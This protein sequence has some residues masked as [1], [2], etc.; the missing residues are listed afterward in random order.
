MKNGKSW[1]CG[2][3]AALLS[4]AASAQTIQNQPNGGI[5][6][7]F[8]YPDSQTY[9][10]VF[11]APDDLVLESFTLYLN[12]AVGSIRGG[13][14]TWNGNGVYARGYGSPVNLFLSDIVSANSAGGYSFNPNIALKKGDFYVAYLS[15][16]GLDNNQIITTTMPKGTPADNLH[17]FVWN[18]STSPFENSAW[19]YSFNVGNVQFKAAFSPSN[20]TYFDGNGARDDGQVTGGAGTWNSSDPSWTTKTGS[21]NGVYVDD[22]LNNIYFAGALGG[23]VDVPGQRQFGTINFDTTGYELGGSGSLEI[24]QSSIFVGRDGSAKISVE[25]K[26][27][28]LTKIGPG[29]LFLNHANS[30]LGGTDLRDGTITVGDDLALGTGDLRMLIGTASVGTTLRSGAANLKLANRIVVR[31]LGIVD[32]RDETFTL[33]G[34][35][36]DEEVNAGSIAKIGR[37]NLVLTAENSY[38]GGTQLRE[39][40]I[41]VGHNKA[42]GTGNLAISD[43]TTLRAG[44]ADLALANNIDIAGLGKVDTG[45]NTLTLNGSVADG[46]QAI[47]TLSK[48]GSGNLVLNGSNSYTGGTN[49]DEGAITV[50]HNNALGTGKLTMAEGTTLRAG[51][52]N[53][54]VANEIKIT[55]QGTFDTGDNTLTISGSI[56]DGIGLA[57]GFVGQWQ[58]DQGPHYGL[59]DRVYTGQ[60]AAAYLFGGSPSDYQISTAGPLVTNINRKSWVSVY[61]SGTVLGCYVGACGRQAP[62]NL[63]KSTN[64]L[65]RSQGDESAYIIDYAVGPQFTNYAFTLVNAVVPSE[66]IKT[67]RGTLVLT[68]ANNYTGGTLL[69]EG[70]LEVANNRALGTGNLA[71][72]DGTTLRAGAADLA[73]ANNINIAGIGKVDTGANT[74]TLNGEITD[75]GEGSGALT[76][77]GTGTLVLNGANSYTGGT[78][79]VAGRLKG[80]STSLQGAIA[81]NSQVEFN[82]SSTGTYAGVMSGTGQF[83]KTG[84]GTL[85]LTGANTYTG[86]TVV[87]A[88]RL[89]GN[90]ASLQGTIVNNSQVEFNQGSTGTYAG[91]MSG[92]GQLIKTG[93]GTL[94]LTGANTYTGGTLV[95]AGRLTGNSASLQGTIVNNSE[96]EFNQSSSGNYAGTMVGSGQLFKTGSGNLTLTGVNNITGQAYVVSGTLTVNNQLAAGGLFVRNTATLAGTGLIG[97]NVTVESGGV[98]APGN[99]PGT[100]SVAGNVTFASGSIFTPEIDGRTYSAAGGAGSYDL[101]SASG[102]ISLSG[103]LTPKLRAISGAASNTFTPRIGDSFIVMSS[104]NVTGSFSGVTQPSDGLPTNTRFDVLYR[105]TNVTLTITPGSYGALALANNWTVNATNAG[106]A[107]DSIRPAAGVRAGNL[108]S[109]FDGIYGLDT[110]QLR[111]T[112]SQISGEVHAQALQS[113]IETERSTFGAMLQSSCDMSCTDGGTNTDKSLWIRYVGNYA[114]FE[115]DRLASGYSNNNNGVVGGYTIVST[116]KVKFGVAASYVENKVNS[117]YGGRSQSQAGAGYLYFHYLPSDRLLLSGA[118]GMSFAD[119]ATTRTVTTTNNSVTATS[120]HQSTSIMINAKAS[121]RT[122]KAGALSLWTNFGLNLVNTSVGRFGENASNPDFALALGKVQQLSGESLVGARLQLDQGPLKVALMTDWIYQVGESPSVIRPVE[123]GNARW[124]VSGA[125]FARS[126]IQLGAQIGAQLSEHL[127]F[128]GMYQYSN[129]GRGHSVNRAVA[130]VRMAF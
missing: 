11:S 57:L 120:K 35:I 128:F 110:D 2:L 77:I 75:G 8:G 5:I 33:A 23:F 119:S 83:I 105:P 31:S 32:T 123:M 52:N 102:T 19:N 122:W 55:R 18:N 114:D 28:G 48:I 81:N 63:V 1:R 100:L 34:Q 94:T 43:G 64:G 115:T 82:Q 71:M 3:V 38:T 53:F 29:E 17:Y 91:V 61:D 106:F 56:G 49:L 96:V 50:G 46:P 80:N 4:T 22:F 73:L 117:I 6:S 26:G 42:L 104:P 14:G 39:G 54:T 58:V 78:T 25:I 103:L 92:T 41:T 60:E 126:G 113:L 70:T 67:G 98:L 97:G 79:V 108:Q 107:L 101:L 30:Y 13:V 37:G 85:T 112:I 40:T 76:K 86:G 68:A 90:S 16:Y 20:F 127:S 109:V 15:K 125:D 62:D 9:G 21:R 93:A 12:G 89:T 88:G 7:A 121:Y 69:K 116:R 24:K 65:Y 66:L 130:G 84:T 45:A 72:S 129:M 36:V 118:V 99:S 44:A 124:N 87:S 47:G 95:F 74:L 111:I 27:T 10:Q 51:A 59:A